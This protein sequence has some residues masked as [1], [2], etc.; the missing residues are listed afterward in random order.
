MLILRGWT[1]HVYHFVTRWGYESLSRTNSDCPGSVR[2]VR[3][4]VG[5]QRVLNGG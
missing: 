1:F 3:I 5:T 2:K 4:P